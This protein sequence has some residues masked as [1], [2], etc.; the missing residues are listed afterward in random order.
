MLTGLTLSPASAGRDTGSVRNWQDYR[1]FFKQTSRLMPLTQ[2]NSP[3]VGLV[4]GV[5]QPNGQ[6]AV[7]FKDAATETMALAA[8]RC[9]GGTT[10]FGLKTLLFTGLVAQSSDRLYVLRR[11]GK[12]GNTTVVDGW[13]F[14]NKTGQIIGT[15]TEG[16]ATATYNLNLVR[17]WN[18][19][20]IYTDGG[21]QRSRLSNAPRNTLPWMMSR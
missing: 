5:L 17:G 9:P 12:S 1:Q 6:F 20:R 10:T 15:C 21:T 11:Q 19:I 8:P 16:N 14:A 2:P 3:T 7:E 13:L 18:V 4:T